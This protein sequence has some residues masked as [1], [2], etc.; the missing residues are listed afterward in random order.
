MIHHNAPIIHFDIGSRIDGFVAHVASFRKI[1]I[2]DIRSLDNFDVNVTFHQLD[3]MSEIPS[4]YFEIT[5]SISCLHTLEHFGLGR[6]GDKIDAFGYL[7]GFKN[8][9]SL[10]KQNGLFYFSVPIGPQR[11]E[12]NA[13]RVFSLNYLLAMFKNDF[14]VINF[15]FVDD[16]GDFY[17]NVILSEERIE[18]NCDCIYGCG[19]FILKKR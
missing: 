14:D 7:K 1:N 4:E 12:F 18:N 15:S 9:T 19:I 8:I 2:F 11:I 3:L 16:I 17:E 6:Y 10:I 13:H 5:D